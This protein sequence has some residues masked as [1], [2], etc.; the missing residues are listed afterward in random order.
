MVFKKAGEI[1][2]KVLRQE[3]GYGFHVRGHAFEKDEN[4]ERLRALLTSAAVR[5]CHL[6]HINK[7]AVLKTLCRW[8]VLD[9]NKIDIVVCLYKMLDDVS[10][11]WFVLKFAC[12]KFHTTLTFLS[13]YSHIFWGSTFYLDTM[14]SSTSITWF[15]LFTDVWGFGLFKIFSVARTRYTEWAKRLQP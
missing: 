12:L 1:F 5:L 7:A 3:K 9:V 2:I 13:N 6:S 14:S 15:R 4:I 10:F 8:C 11:C